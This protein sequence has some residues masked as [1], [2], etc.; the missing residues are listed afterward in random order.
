MLLIDD[1]QIKQIEKAGIEAQI[2]TLS[3]S[4]ETISGD[5][6]AAARASF[7]Q[8]CETL[9][10]E[11]TNKEKEFD[12]DVENLDKLYADQHDALLREM[13]ESAEQASKQRE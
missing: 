4:I 8:Y 5:L 2:A 11:Y 1:I 10:Y 12:A 6:K 13:F 9:D 3:N 7:E